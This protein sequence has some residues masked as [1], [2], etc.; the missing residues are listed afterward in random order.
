MPADQTLSTVS[1]EN[2]ECKG[3][4]SAKGPDLTIP[5]RQMDTLHKTGG[6]ELEVRS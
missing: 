1:G 6:G 5:V 2:A 4:I 3:R